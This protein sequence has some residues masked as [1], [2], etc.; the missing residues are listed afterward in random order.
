MQGDRITN[1]QRTGRFVIQ[2]GL[3]DDSWLGIVWFAS[4]A[5]THHGL[6]QLHIQS[7]KDSLISALPTRATGGTCIGCG[8][9]KALEVCLTCFFQYICRCVVIFFR[10]KII[11]VKC[12][13]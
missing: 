8:I 6:V 9:D 2:Q 13:K 1:L 3:S 12:F 4:S 5:S 7:A 10:L 11:S